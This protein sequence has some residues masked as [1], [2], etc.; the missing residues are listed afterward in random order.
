MVYDPAV[1]DVAGQVATPEEGRFKPEQPVMA[2]AAPPEGVA[3][4]VTVPVGNV[5]PV[6]CGV[7][8]A[9]KVTG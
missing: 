9:V 4:K 3:V 1:R 5:V 2:A 8:V 6:N 7:I